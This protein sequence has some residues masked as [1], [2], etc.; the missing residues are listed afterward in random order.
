[1][2]STGHCPRAGSKCRCIADDMLSLVRGLRCFS[3]LS[4]QNFT[5]SPKL[6]TDGLVVKDVQALSNCSC[7]LIRFS[8]TYFAPTCFVLVFAT[9]F[10]PSAAAVL[11][12]RP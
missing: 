4:C 3:V 6:A 2:P 7:V 10:G 8:S 12:H 1:M 5:R 9:A 11:T